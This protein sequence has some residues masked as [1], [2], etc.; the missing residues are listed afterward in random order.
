MIKAI[1][2]N[3]KNT[4]S[5]VLPSNKKKLGTENVKNNVKVISRISK[6]LLKKQS[7]NKKRKCKR[8]IRVLKQKPYAFTSAYQRIVKATKEIRFH[9]TIRVTPNNV[10][11][12]LKDLIQNKIIV[13]K[14]AGLVKLKVSKKTLKFANKLIV[15]NFIEQILPI[16]Q[17]KTE[18]KVILSIRGPIKIKKT[19]VKQFTLLALKRILLVLQVLNIKCFNGCRPKKKKTKKTKKLTC[20]KIKL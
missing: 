2:N 20:I 14:S 19:I 16:L 15:Q 5:S 8:L 7:Q 12:T 6:Y 3:K 10:F 4:V 18:Q 1:K 11:C 9:I 13:I 17:S